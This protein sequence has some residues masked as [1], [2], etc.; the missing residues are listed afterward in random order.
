MDVKT[1]VVTAG[2]A[3]FAWGTFL[4]VASMRMNGMKQ[5]V[6]VG[7][8]GWRDEMKRRVEALGGVT[9]FYSSM[10]AGFGNKIHTETKARNFDLF[11]RMLR[12]GAGRDTR[13]RR[14]HG[15]LLPAVH[16]AVDEGRPR[17]RAASSHARAHGAVFLRQPVAADADD[18]Q[19]RGVILSTILALLFIEIPWETRV[20]FTCYFDAAQRRRPRGCEI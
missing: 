7:A 12:A 17:S 5:P 16:R 14:D 1:T 3:N 10:T 4:L 13:L 11:M 9:I 6:L 20:V 19:V 2:D 18:V 8:M 15:G